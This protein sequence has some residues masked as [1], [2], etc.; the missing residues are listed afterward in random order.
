VD[1]KDLQQ[2]LKLAPALPIPPEHIIVV[3][4]DDGNGQSVAFLINKVPP[5][6]KYAHLV[7][8]VIY[9]AFELR[10]K[11]RDRISCLTPY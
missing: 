8:V 11:L 4:L 9:S 2:A 10:H 3:D 7:P 5:V 6:L 1:L